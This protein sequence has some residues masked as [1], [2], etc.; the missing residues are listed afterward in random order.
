[1]FT[2]F[3]FTNLF[4]KGLMKRYLNTT[5]TILLL[6]FS[7]TVFS[8]KE[9]N[10][11]TSN[12]IAVQKVS[13]DFISNQLK[14]VYGDSY[15]QY[16]EPRIEFFTDFYNRCEFVSLDKA[17][18][19]LINISEL[20]LINKYSKTQM[21]HDFNMKEF[22]RANFNV[23][24]YFLNYYSADAQYFKIYNTNTVLKINGVKK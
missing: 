18:P 13:P 5:I 7:L 20:R 16:G 3:C 10:N 1:M 12:Q 19:E 11:S 22:D 6:F 15:K 9:S 8:Q 23:F 4:I 17:P 14:E 24:K 2:Y 21:N